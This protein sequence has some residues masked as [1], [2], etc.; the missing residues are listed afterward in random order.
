MY[1]ALGMLGS[2]L[3]LTS[4]QNAAVA[5]VLWVVARMHPALLAG[6]ILIL[7]VAARDNKE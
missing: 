2:G 5:T 3:F 4:W 6:V 7:V 1:S